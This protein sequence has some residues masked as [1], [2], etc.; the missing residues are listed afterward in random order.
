MVPLVVYVDVDD[1]LIRT[2]GSKRIPVSGVIES[3]AVGLGIAEL[4]AG[5]LPKPQ[6]L[7]DDRA[8]AQWN[9]LIEIHP[10]ECG[11]WNA[12]DYQRAVAGD[13]KLNGPC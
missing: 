6:V 7:V 2:S 5:F 12:E 10:S 9:R 4:F 1:T 11:R 3:V 13:L 8:L